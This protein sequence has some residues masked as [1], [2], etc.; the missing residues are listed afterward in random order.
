MDDYL[1]GDKWWCPCC[2]DD[3]LLR[4]NGNWVRRFVPAQNMNDYDAGIPM[5]RDDNSHDLW[6][7]IAK[8]IERRYSD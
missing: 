6:E 7:D 3:R 8:L 4:P 1:E 5:E 2:R